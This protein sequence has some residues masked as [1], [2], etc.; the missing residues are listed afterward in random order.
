MVAKWAI[1]IGI[2]RSHIWF[3]RRSAI[4]KV[5]E[6]ESWNTPSHLHKH[7]HTHFKAHNMRFILLSAYLSHKNNHP[8]GVTRRVHMIFQL[9]NILP[10]WDFM[11]EVKNPLILL[12][13][14][15]DSVCN[16][17]AIPRSSKQEQVNSKEKLIDFDI[18]LRHL[19]AKYG[20]LLII[21]EILSWK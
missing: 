10:Y 3:F 16:N 4:L 6:G 14:F 15:S 18:P 20:Y 1:V 12:F 8:Y 7:S 5:N 21:K 13:F 19:S 11:N 17:Q 2:Y 9:A